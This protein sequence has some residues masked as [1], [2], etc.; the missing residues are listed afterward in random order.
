MA[1]RVKYGG[2]Q[3][4]TLNKTTVELKDI[5]KKY[6]PHA[7]E[8]LWSIANTSKSDAA[9]VSAIKELLDRAY[10]KA[11]QSMTLKGDANNPLMIVSKGQR[12]A[13][14]AAGLRSNK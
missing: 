8:K 10:G 14:L 4:G 11:A 5:A 7:I 2:R 3:K 1:P 13:S 12:D 9:K 6:G